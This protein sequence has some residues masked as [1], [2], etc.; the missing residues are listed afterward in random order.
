MASNRLIGIPR[1]PT[2]VV[3]VERI[4]SLEDDE[5][6]RDDLPGMI[7][8]L[9]PE[10]ETASQSAHALLGEEPKVLRR[11]HQ[12]PS[13]TG[14]VGYRRTEVACGNDDNAAGLELALTERKRLPRLREMLDYVEQNDDIHGTKGLQRGCIRHP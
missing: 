10:L 7:H 13:R 9:E 14:E 11:R 5:R 4:P 8:M 1:R 6:G 3:L 2:C 12:P